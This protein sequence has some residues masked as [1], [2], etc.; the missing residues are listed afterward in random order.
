MS[1]IHVKALVANKKLSLLV[2]AFY[3]MYDSYFL[4]LLM[5]YFIHFQLINNKYL[6]IFV[7]PQIHRNTRNPNTRRRA[8][9]TRRSSTPL[10]SMSLPPSTRSTASPAPRL[11]FRPTLGMR[12]SLT[13]ALLSKVE[14]PLRKRYIFF[15]MLP[16]KYN[17]YT[18]NS[19]KL[20]YSKLPINVQVLCLKLSR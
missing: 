13:R 10:E 11:C 17:L 14:P 2:Y 5:E 8:T 4:R 9:L 3:I 19:Y 18:V 7:F 16:I 12:A 6:V 20:L 1:E 15:K